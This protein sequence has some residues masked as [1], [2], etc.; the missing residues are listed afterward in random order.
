MLAKQVLVLSRVAKTY[1]AGVV[2]CAAAID[3]L[4]GLSLRLRAGE[5]AVVEG[6][7]GAGKTTLLLCAAGMIHPDEGQVL[8]PS[9]VPRPG[10]PPAGIG[11]ASDR[12]PAYGFLT[13][14]ESL[15]YAATV[16][17]L[18]APGAACGAAELLELAELRDYADTR[19]VLLPDSE[20]ARLLVAMA[21]V[22]SPRLL[23]VDDLVGGTSAHGA[24]AFA[25]CLTCA[26]ASGIGVLWAASAV[27]AEARPESAYVL[28]DGRLRRTRIGPTRRT[29]VQAPPRLVQAFSAART[30]AALE[31]E[32]ATPAAASSAV[33]EH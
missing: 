1:R 20:R 12:A 25:R 30:P 28:A 3:G 6:G 22:A 23:L 15:A 13:V 21:L 11:Y 18:R 32:Q 10:R 7:R 24:A 8:W 2:G 16:C 4:R 26:A 17:E 5:L 29:G 31:R 27:R 33:R 14:R 9:L 19:Q